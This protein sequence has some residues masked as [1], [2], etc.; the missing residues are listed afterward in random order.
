[1][2]LLLVRHGQP[3]WAPEQTYATNDP[4]LT[5][6][7]RRQASLLAKAASGW[8]PVDHI[9]V[10]PM[11]RAR[12]T[13]APLVE[14]LSLDPLVQDWMM[15]IGNPDEWEGSPVEEVDEILAESNLRSIDEMWDGLPGGESFR[16]FHQRVVD[17]LEKSLSDVGVTRLPER[18]PH[19][20]EV[21]NEELRVVLVAH[22]GTNAV[23]LGTLL[24]VE[25]TPWEWDRFSSVHTGIAR[26]ATEKIAEGRAFSLRTFNDVGHLSADLITA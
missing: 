8:A 10:S 16:R 14:A 11:L 1:M 20:W 22:G 21:E 15:E 19:L 2:E 6:L 17:G 13:A 25:P 12:Q 24:G 3:D 9:W 18:H 23:I 7:G 5:P 26:V 4:V